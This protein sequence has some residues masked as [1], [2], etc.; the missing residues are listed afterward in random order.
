MENWQNN[1]RKEALVDQRMPVSVSVV[2]SSEHRPQVCQNW[3]EGIGEVQGCAAECLRG[4]SI[5]EKGPASCWQ[6][7]G[8]FKCTRRRSPF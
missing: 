6:P 5:S 3:E 4:E 1:P 8:E 7:G 2:M